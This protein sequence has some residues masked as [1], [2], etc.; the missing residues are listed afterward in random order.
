MTIKFLVYIL[1]DENG[2]V[3][4]Y[5]VTKESGNNICLVGRDKN[6]QYYQFDSCEAYHS[7]EWAETK[8]F[9]VECVEKEITI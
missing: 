8:G 3:M 6:G 4:D 7:Y 5:D 9:T 2:E 1:K